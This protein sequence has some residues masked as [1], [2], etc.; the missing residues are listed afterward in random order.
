MNPG[1]VRSSKNSA[2]RKLG[3]SLRALRKQS[4]YTIDELADKVHISAKTLA[5]IEKA[6]SKITVDKLFA[7]AEVLGVAPEEL[8]RRASSPLWRWS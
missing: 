6:E 5:R 8:V 3:A 2:V 4:G 7:L 1:E